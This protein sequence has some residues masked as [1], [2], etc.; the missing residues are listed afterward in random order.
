MVFRTPTHLES[1]VP[2]PAEQVPQSRTWSGLF[3]LAFPDAGRSTYQDIYVTAAETDGDSRMDLWPGHLYVYLSQRRAGLQDIVSWVAHHSP[4]VCTFMPDNHPDPAY[5]TANHG[6]FLSF[7]QLLLDNQMVAFAPWNA[8]DR[9]PGAGIM[10]YPTPTS[11]SVLV[12]AMFLS[13]PF[14]NFITFSQQS[15]ASGSSIQSP[16][17]ALYQTGGASS[18]FGTLEPTLTSPSQRHH[19]YGG[20]AEQSLTASY[21][22]S[23]TP[24]Q[25]PNRGG[26]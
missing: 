14:P 13:G 19:P 11:G 10:I 8:P 17:A 16:Q 20:P 21:P 22:T 4:P 23:S 26:R 18:T 24:W 5:T 15:S 2:S 9:L 1:L 12:G 6:N 7:S 3:T 25:G